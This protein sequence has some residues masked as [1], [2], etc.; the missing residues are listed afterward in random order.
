M[1]VLSW[2]VP[3]KEILLAGMR[4]LLY[5]GMYC[6][7]AAASNTRNT[8]QYVEL[9]SSS[10]NVGHIKRPRRVAAWCGRVIIPFGREEELGRNGFHSVA[11]LG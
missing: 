6:T 7:M 3:W 11:F 2:P 8:I 4:L 5:H 1:N 9:R 10:Q